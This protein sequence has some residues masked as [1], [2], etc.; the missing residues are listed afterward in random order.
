MFEAIEATQGFR[1]RG[2]HV[3]RQRA[4]RRGELAY[5]LPQRAVRRR[6][7]AVGVAETADVT[8]DG[9]GHQVQFSPERLELHPDIYAQIVDVTLEPGV[10]LRQQPQ[11]SAERFSDDIEVTPHLVVHLHQGRA[12]LGVH[13]SRW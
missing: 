1:L 3:A 10:P 2:S 8:A 12:Q 13:E 5:F 11:V 4:V 6:Q 9:T 7:I